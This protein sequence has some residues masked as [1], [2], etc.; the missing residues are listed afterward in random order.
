MRAILRLYPATVVSTVLVTGAFV[1][2]WFLP[3]VPL[4][5]RDGAAIADGQWWRILTSFLVQGSGWG[6]Y[7]FNT[8][9]LL[10]VGGA[11]ERTRG[12]AWW[13]TGALAAQVVTSLIVLAWDPVT[14]DSGS[15]LVVSGLVG[16]LAVTRF[17]RPVGWAATAAGYRIFFVS[18]LFALALGG[19]VAGAI[20]GSV[21]T[22]VAVSLLVRS[23]FAPWSLTIALAI[24]VV[25]S[26][27]LT[28]VRDAHG[29]AVLVGLVVAVLGGWFSRRR[30]SG[31]SDA[32]P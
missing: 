19:P 29:V 5:E 4:L 2:Q 21:V 10:I 6:Q 32:R 18:Y 7:V 23:R 24:V 8:L 26:V 25:G 16:V 20:V 27:G 14:R 1:L 28:I 13:L 22:G 31:R 11:V 12:T 9:G 3:L 30:V 15:S 17:V